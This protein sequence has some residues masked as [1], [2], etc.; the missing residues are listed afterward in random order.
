MGCVILLVRHALTDAVGVRLTSRLPGVLLNARGLEQA[1]ELGNLLEQAPLTAIYS[2]PLERARATASAIAA[3]HRIRVQ[4]LDALD[5][6]HFGEWSGLTFE[7]LSTVPGWRE[8]NQTRGTA[9]VPGGERA[10][11]V[12]RRIM[13]ALDHLQRRHD[14]E[15]IAVVSHADVIRAAVL[16]VT[17]TPL[18][19]WHRFEI[20]PASITTIAYE[21][22]RPRLVAVNTVPERI[23]HHA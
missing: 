1:A 17:A 18:D 15:T 13:T 3:P 6:V 7:E 21:E 11:Q 9:N 4:T 10:E 16:D 22:G 8:F 14:G 23:G 2:S 12:Q 19:L 20:D 5:E